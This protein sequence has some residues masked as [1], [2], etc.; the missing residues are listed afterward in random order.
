MGLVVFEFCIGD[1]KMVFVFNSNVFLSMI[2]NYFV[3]EICCVDFIF[4]IF[5]DDD[6][7]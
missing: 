5:Y 6:I 7:V 2:I 3:N 1:N 4:D